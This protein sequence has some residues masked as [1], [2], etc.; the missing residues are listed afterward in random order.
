MLPHVLALPGEHRHGSDAT[1]DLRRNVQPIDVS[2][3]TIQYAVEE[4]LL[5]RR[6]IEKEGKFLPAERDGFLDPSRQTRS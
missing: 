6:E 4:L 5:G 2:L 1:A 3:A